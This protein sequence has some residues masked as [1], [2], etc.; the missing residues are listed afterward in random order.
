V[1]NAEVTRQATMIA[2][3]DDFKLM[4][5]LTLAV[6]PLLWLI[7]QRGVALNGDDME[8]AIPEG[9]CKI[10]ATLV[11]VTIT[12][13]DSAIQARLPCR[14]SSAAS[15]CKQLSHLSSHPCTSTRVVRVSHAM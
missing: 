5:I 14:S 13:A 1:L 2:Y 7:T 9:A 11:D 8:I 12:W 10:D 15:S 4:L 3:V 6:I